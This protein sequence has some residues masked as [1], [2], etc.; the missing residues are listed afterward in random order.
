MKEDLKLE[1]FF[2]KSRW[3]RAIREAIEKKL[4]RELITLYCKP[5]YRAHLFRYIF[6]QKYN[7]APPHIVEIP[8][9]NGKFREVYVNEDMDR[10]VLSIIGEIYSELYRDRIHKSCV[11]YQKGVGVSRIVRCVSEELKR[12]KESG[13]KSFGYKVDISKY[14]DSYPKELLYSDLDSI[15]TGSP[16]DAIVQKYYREDIVINKDNKVEERYK[17]IAQGCAVSPFLANY[18]LRDIDKKMEEIGVMYYRYSDDAIIIGEQ[19]DHAL[20]VFKKMLKDK[21]LS[22]NCEKIEKIEDEKWFTFLGFRINCDKISFSK[23]TLKEFQKN[24]KLL[25]PCNKELRHKKSS[26]IKAIRDINKYL[27]TAFLQSHKNFGWAEYFFS[28]VNIPEDIMELDMFIKD[29]IRA[30]YTGR[31]NVGGLGTSNRKNRGVANRTGVNVGSNKKDISNKDLKNLGYVSMHY[32]YK[33][34]RADK[35]VYRVIV[36]QM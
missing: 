6:E 1:M 2:D 15:D 12:M 27:Y 9:E 10:I 25:T 7:V 33:L 11:S 24:I 20:S 26:Q 30:V 4:D 18:A 34:Y 19:S 23:K 32:L 8:K 14:F 36:Q 29:R 21:G 31:S 13:V 17:S 16:I 28:A 3:D 35:S 5:E 22:L